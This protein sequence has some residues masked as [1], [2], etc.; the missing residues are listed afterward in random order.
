MAQPAE[1]VPALCSHLNIEWASRDAF[2]DAGE[3]ANRT[4][5]AGDERDPKQDCLTLPC[6]SGASVA[7]SFVSGPNF[8]TS[9]TIFH[10]QRNQN[11]TSLASSKADQDEDCFNQNQAFA[12]LHRFNNCLLAEASGR[13]G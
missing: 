9:L 3:F 5:Q 6:G 2:G 10:L 7:I 8:Y 4:G 1:F 11:F 12:P 13:K